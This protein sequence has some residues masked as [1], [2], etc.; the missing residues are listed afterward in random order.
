VGRAVDEEMT[1]VRL[2]AVGKDHGGTAASAVHRAKRGATRGVASF[3]GGFSP[4]VNA[5]GRIPE[6]RPPIARHFNP[7]LPAQ[8]RAQVPL[9]ATEAEPCVRM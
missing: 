5:D 9:E 3:A 4:R 1:E 7:G 6:G 2:S 8:M